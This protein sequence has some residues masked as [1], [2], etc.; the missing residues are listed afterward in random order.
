MQ[1]SR[2]RGI[3][4]AVDVATTLTPEWE[5]VFRA[6]AAQ[7]D[8]RC[9]CGGPAERDLQGRARLC[10][11]CRALVLLGHA[12]W[13]GVNLGRCAGGCRRWLPTAQMSVLGAPGAPELW[14]A[15]CLAGPIDE[16]DVL[17]P[18]P[19]RDDWRDWTPGGWDDEPEDNGD[20]REAAPADP[21]LDRWIAA[22]DPPD[23]RPAALASFGL[24]E[25]QTETA[26]AAA[27]CGERTLGLVLREM[28]WLDEWE[29]ARITHLLL[30]R[31]YDAARLASVGG[32]TRNGARS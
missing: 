2:E 32:P 20:E 1:C 29:R 21:D 7:A 18:A 30:P 16:T 6:R 4:T 9:G 10:G 3:V 25:R 13:A 12:A 19:P 8:P 22:S 31:P 14:C 17:A 27:A 24:N 28:P 11:R 5:R 23:W 15:D 26:V